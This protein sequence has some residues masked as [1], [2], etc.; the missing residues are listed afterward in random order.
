[1]RKHS[2]IKHFKAVVTCS[3]ALA[4]LITLLFVTVQPTQAAGFTIT[5]DQ[6]DEDLG[7]E[8][9]QQQLFGGQV[10][11][12]E[13]GGELKHSA[14]SSPAIVVLNSSNDKI[15]NSGLI[16]TDKNDSV[17]IRIDHSDNTTINNIGK[18]ST[19]GTNSHGIKVWLAADD[20]NADDT[21]NPDSVIINNSGNIE[22]EGKGSV[23][24]MVT[25]WSKGGNEPGN[26]TPVT[27][28]TTTINIDGGNNGGGISATYN[29]GAEL[30]Y[31]I[32]VETIYENDT[33][34]NMGTGGVT[35]LNLYNGSKINGHIDLGTGIDKVTIGYDN[36][37]HFGSN[38]GKTETVNGNF[39]LGSGDNTFIMY[40]NSTLTVTGDHTQLDDNGDPVLDDNGD[41]VVISHGIT[42]GEGKDTFTFY[43]GSKLTAASINTG[44]GADTLFFSGSTV[45]VDNI[46]TGA[47]AADEEGWLTINDDDG[48]D[49]NV[50]GDMLTILNSTVSVN[51]KI[52]LGAGDDGEVSTIVEDDDNESITVG[53]MLT[54]LNSTVSATEIKTGDGAD[55][56]T[57]GAS[58]VTANIKTGAGGDLV[59]VLGVSKING[60]VDLGSGE[61]I[62][63]LDEGSIL[64]AEEINTGAGNDQM[65]L[66]SDSEVTVGNI[67]FGIGPEN[68]IDTLDIY[69]SLEVANNIEFGGG[70]DK[71]T[72]YS[73]SEV[74]AG[75]IDF[76]GGADTMTLNTGSTVTASRIDFGDGDDKM[77]LYSGS[78]IAGDIYFGKGDDWATINQGADITGSSFDFGEGY[79]TLE[80][81]DAN[82]TITPNYKNIGSSEP[83]EEN[84]IESEPEPENKIVDASSLLLP[85][86]D[87]TI[88]T[89]SKTGQAAKG[90]VLSSLCTGLHGVVNKRLTHFKPAQIKL[91]ATRIT[92][93]MLKTPKQPQAWGDVFRSYR[94]RD[95]ES[96]VPGYD[97]EFKGFTGGLERSINRLR[98]GLLGGYSHAVTEADNKTFQ[99]KSNS[100][101]GGAYGQYDFGRIKLAASLIGG[102]EDHDNDRYL[103]DNLFGAE[104]ARADFGSIFL[105]P[106]VTVSADFTVAHRLLLRPSATVVYSAGWYDDYHE[107]G[108][109]QSNLLMDSRT[110]QTLNPQLQMAAVYTFSDWCELELNAG[111]TARYMDTGTV[112]GNVSG[113]SDFRFT[114]SGDDNVY[115]AQVGG[116]L[117]ADVTDRLELYINAQFTDATGGETQDFFMAG[118]K[119]KF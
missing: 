116:Y 7:A 19:L 40:E 43:E 102:Y 82:V 90:P 13:A 26:G 55:I 27:G 54:I 57:I 33:S 62:F 106:S 35:N 32:K 92:P 72:L 49:I 118:L 74:T 103:T 60:T 69:G 79:D 114:T 105:S 1:M 2:S 36:E 119:F 18:I 111:G 10:G 17:A 89:L 68:D 44:A 115:G 50:T 56:L 47:G 30:G 98:I 71:M 14:E 53:D 63:Y 12:I 100:Y 37:L 81:V 34:H 5:S 3:V 66:Y 20:T 73:G 8:T 4:L 109:T 112:N 117:S 83:E 104:T 38:T 65:T 52:E 75:S 101:F 21:P 108:T 93:G 59:G 11:I 97:H 58:N 113:G 46:D 94:K 107:H 25:E 6:N 51:D 23:G 67:Y 99:T 96:G 110:I 84:R 45:N 91:A 76:S 87:G 24:I 31:A 78:N 86:D 77:T 88:M 95:D 15:T 42:T 39:D 28:L 64:S 61:D 9:D 29:S 22:V 70:A 80:I 16:L 48:Y 85:T 41:Q